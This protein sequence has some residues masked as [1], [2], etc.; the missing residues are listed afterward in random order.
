METAKKLYIT[1]PGFGRV[2]HVFGEDNRSLCG[3]AMMLGVDPNRC[4]L[5]DGDEVY[6]K[7]QDCKPCWRKA[8][9]K[10]ES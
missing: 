6:K 7:G 10:V 2:F 3:G 1:H 5:V 4:S 8:G 9:L